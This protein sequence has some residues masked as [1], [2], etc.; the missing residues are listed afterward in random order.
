MRFHREAREDA[1]DVVV[2]GSGVGGLVAGGVLAR[3]GRKAAISA[4]NTN[5]KFPKIFTASQHCENVWNP[6]KI[7]PASPTSI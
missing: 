7:R 6:A 4:T 3:L 5:Y 2:I 1:Y